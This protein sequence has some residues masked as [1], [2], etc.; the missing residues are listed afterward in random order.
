MSTARRAG[1]GR[2][3]LVCALALEACAS[4]QQ[5]RSAMR[6]ADEARQ[7]YES[8]MERF[9]DE[10]WPE[11][12]ELFEAVKR[13]YS[14][15]R[16]GW[17]AE[18][19]L[20]DVAFHQERYSDALSAYRSWIRY[21]PTQT[22]V[23]HAQFMIAKCYVAQMPDDWLLVPPSYE[24]DLS[25]ARDAESA[26]ARFIRDHEDSD[27]VAEARRLH[28]QVRE[29]LAN[30]ELYVANFYASR[31]RWNAAIHR[32]LGVIANF[33]GS[34][35]EP[36]ALVQLGEIYLRTGHQPEARGAF[37]QV[38]EEHPRTPEAEAARSFLARVGAGPTVPVDA[39][40]YRRGTS[41]TPRPDPERTR[42][43]PSRRGGRS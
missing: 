38:V 1:R 25:S 20:A 23:A 35:R 5:P 34:G 31:D 15:S 24:R 32:L 19:R 9:R 41:T 14:S 29:T 40:G 8:A 10:E 36:R 13:D 4:T 39:S 16:W 7:A 33:E 28:R 30:H 43:A 42:P 37:Q 22:E 17:M 3:V 12:Q 11:A 21:H 18:L 27:H 6:Y 2:F 26:L